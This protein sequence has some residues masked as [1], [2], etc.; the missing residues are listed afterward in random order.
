MNDDGEPGKNRYKLQDGLEK[1]EDRRFFHLT[2]ANANR[3]ISPAEDVQVSLLSFQE[4][5]P[6]GSW[7]IAW[8]G[9][10]PLTW[11]NQQVSP[12][13]RTIGHSYD[14]DLCSVGKDLGFS[15]ALLVLPF[16]LTS[17]INRKSR[18]NIILAL[19][20]R[21][22]RTDSRTYRFKIAWDGEWED[23]GSEMKKH[24][25]ITPLTNEA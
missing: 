20:A 9:D 18:L 10:I 15:L 1:E 2:V 25:V 16:N 11:R 22:R 13:L 23:I 5:G 17:Y 4:E 21:G 24:L 19:Q 8:V 14:C 7:H 12:I 3:R 6:G